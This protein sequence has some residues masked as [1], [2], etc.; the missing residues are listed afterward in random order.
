MK[1]Q[2]TEYICPQCEG[3]LD[4]MTTETKQWLKCRTPHCPYNRSP[5][6]LS[7]AWKMPRSIGSLLPPMLPFRIQSQLFVRK[8]RSKNHFPLRFVSLEDEPKIGSL[9][10]TPSLPGRFFE[11]EN[12]VHRADYPPLYLFG[13]LRNKLTQVIATPDMPIITAKEEITF[14]GL[15]TGTETPEESP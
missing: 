15:I 8:G 9:I 12:L 6:S 7:S 5:Q 3:P 2:P 11:V 14:E 4:Y 13:I 1:R 10:A